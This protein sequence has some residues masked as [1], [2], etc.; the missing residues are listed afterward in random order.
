MGL[1]R[2][3][4]YMVV[5]A[6]LRLVGGSHDDQSKDLELFVLRHQLRVLRRKAGRPRLTPLDRVLL[7]AASRVLPRDRWAAFL[8]TPQTLLRW[9]REFVGR[10][11]TFRRRGKSG[12]PR[13]DA[14]VRDLI[15]RLA[16]ENP[17][18]GCIRISGELRML[19]I[20]AGATT[21]RRLLRAHGLGPAPRRSGPTW[22]E[23]LRA[24]ANGD[25]GLRLPYGGDDQAQV[26]TELNGRR[27]RFLIRDHD[28]KFTASF[29]EVFRTEGAEVIRT[30]IRAPKANAYAER[31]VSTVRAKCL[32]W[33]MVLGSRH[34]ERVL[35]TYARHYNQ[36]RPHRGLAL[37]VPEPQE[38]ST[39]A[40]ARYVRRRDVLGGLIHEYRRVAA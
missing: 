1:L 21:V 8:V 38:P 5:R 12:R 36:H 37:D 16:R 28:A 19:G 33:V 25:P 27:I 3:L 31:W 17:Q 4:P 11:W 24:Q 32:D 2:F 39:P 13:I 29:D 14:E 20:R 30:P 7:A 18:W 10:K 22:S 40:R 26:A 23:F 35:R 15:V 6:I 9:H 34:L